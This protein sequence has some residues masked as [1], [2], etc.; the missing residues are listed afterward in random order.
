MNPMR[1]GGF[2]VSLLLLLG[3]AASPLL[4]EGVPGM[5][6]LQLTRAGD[7]YVLLTPFELLVSRDG[8]AWTPVGLRGRGDALTGVGGGKDYIL[9]ATASG[10]LLRV[11]PE[12]R[13]LEGVDPVLKDPF[14]RPAKGLRHILVAKGM[15]LASTGQGLF[16]SLDEGKSWTPV[17]PFWK[18]QKYRGVEWLGTAGGVP[19][20]M[21]GSGPLRLGKAGFEP[22]RKGLP[23]EGSLAAMAS[24]E[25]RMLVAHEKKGIFEARD[26]ASWAPVGNGP[27]TLL[28]FLGWAGKEYLA[29]GPF[30]PLNVGT[31]KGW[32]RISDFSP[33]FT[34]VGSVSTPAGALVAFRGKGLFRW[35]AKGGLVPVSLPMRLASLRTSI[36]AGGGTLWGTEGGLYLEEGGAVR[37]VTPAGLGGGVNVLAK[38]PDGTILAGTAGFG[39]FV[40]RDQGKSWEDVNGSGKT[41]LSAANSIAAM[42]LLDG[43]VLVATEGGLKKGTLTMEAAGKASGSWSPALT[44]ALAAVPAYAIA[45]HQGKVWAA[46]DGGLVSLAP[47]GEST[48]EAG[49]TSPVTAV[50][51]NGKVLAALTNGR[52]RVREGEG[53]WKELPPLAAGSP[54]ALLVSGEKVLAGTLSGVWQWNGTEWSQAAPPSLPVTALV[55]DGAGVRAITRGG[56]T[57]TF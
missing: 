39:V 57:F 55:A 41:A 8:A 23:A 24:E 4:A 3:L 22:F 32:K 36:P 50:S 13:L 34:P 16:Q 51:S 56:G 43:S 25:G 11:S 2:L 52:I 18:E 12:G 28:A 5:E 21:T 30:S 29:A 42:A 17:E 15:V 6:T 35:D 38:R 9:V 14:G 46:T 48:P 40:S 37:D 44:G 27:E 45:L 10:G 53:S 33:G 7:A 19:V 1:M 47:S 31:P 49:F 20:V 54:T 26:D